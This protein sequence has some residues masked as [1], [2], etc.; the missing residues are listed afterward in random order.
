MNCDERRLNICKQNVI[1]AA[2]DLEK[3][4]VEEDKHIVGGAPV[5]LFKLRNALIGYRM[6]LEGIRR[7]ENDHE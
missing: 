5:S 6:A 1:D 7:R 2:I 3:W 4:W